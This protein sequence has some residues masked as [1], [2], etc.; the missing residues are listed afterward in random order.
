MYMT[1]SRAWLK[2]SRDTL[3]TGKFQP[4]DVG[5]QKVLKHHIRHSCHQFLVQCAKQQAE[6]GIRSHNVKLPTAIGPLRNASASWVTDAFKWICS[7]PLTILRVS[8]AI[9]FYLRR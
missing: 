5:V 4:A 1:N 3:G 9:S 6:L 2:I 7:K 8:N